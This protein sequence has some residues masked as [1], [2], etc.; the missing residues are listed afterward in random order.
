MVTDVADMKR[1]SQIAE[2][3]KLVQTTPKLNERC[4]E[5]IA[6]AIDAA[7]SHAEIYREEDLPTTK[8]GKDAIKNVGVQLRRLQA[9]LNNDALHYQFKRM[10]EIVDGWILLCDHYEQR[11]ARRARQRDPS[12]QIAARKAIRIMQTFATD[13]KAATAVTKKGRL[14]KLAA[15]I[16]GKPN[17]DLHHEVRFAKL[18]FPDHAGFSIEMIDAMED[19]QIVEPLAPS[20]IDREDSEDEDAS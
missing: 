14:S 1:E 19:L 10:P 11:P 12:R 5:A 8:S 6:R 3:L 18:N 20:D 13:R 17:E 15:R 2:A 9:A 16:A 7:T 4:K